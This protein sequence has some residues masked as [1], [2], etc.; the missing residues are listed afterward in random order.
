MAPMNAPTR[1]SAGPI[2]EETG[3]ADVVGGAGVD[4]LVV[5]G[6]AGQ[7]RVGL[8]VDVHLVVP[9]RVGWAVGVP[10]RTHGSG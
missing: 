9:A 2:I 4:A 6:D 5:G 8:V 3:P 1:T 7:S 10:I